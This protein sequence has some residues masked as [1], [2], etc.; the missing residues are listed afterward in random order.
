MGLDGRAFGIAPNKTSGAQSSFAA[1]YAGF[2]A[3]EAAITIS[4]LADAAPVSYG[5]PAAG[6]VGISQM[7]TVLNGTA[8]VIRRSG[9]AKGVPVVN[10]IAAVLTAGWFV[11]EA[12]KANKACSP[13]FGF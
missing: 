6:A 7:L 11:A 3:C 5:V 10:E 4:D 12:A 9:L 1:R 8:R 2:L 13:Q